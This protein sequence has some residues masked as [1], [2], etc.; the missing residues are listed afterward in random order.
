[1][2]KNDKRNTSLAYRPDRALDV[3]YHQPCWR[4]A[5]LMVMYHFMDEE[6]LGQRGFAIC[7]RSQSK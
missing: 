1:M 7:R 2:L 3:I 5:A 6:I 4:P